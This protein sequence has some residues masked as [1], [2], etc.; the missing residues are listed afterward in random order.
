M[1]ICRCFL[2]FGNYIAF[3]W[4]MCICWEAKIYTL[5]FSMHKLINPNYHEIL[6]VYTKERPA[7]LLPFLESKTMQRL[8]DISQACGTDY[9]K[10]YNYKFKQSRL[11]HSL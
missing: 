4:K 10:F 9:C 2:K 11:D 5:Y 6:N 8:S 3:Y 1:R 7:F